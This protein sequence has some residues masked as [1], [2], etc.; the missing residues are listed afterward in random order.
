MDS[1]Q[2]NETLTESNL[3]E[4][5]E[6][7]S[8]FNGD[9]ITKKD[10]KGRFLGKGGFAKCYELK[11]VS[12]KKVFAGKIISKA[13][14]IKPSAKNKLKSEIKIHKSLSHPNIVKFE[15]YFED[16]E[17]V[18]ILLELCKSKTLN[19]L[20]K[21]RKILSEI[22]VKYYLFQILNAVKF[23]HKSKVIHRDLKLG[24]L[25]LSGSLEIKIGDFGLATR[26]EYDG[27][28]KHTV[29]GTPNY[30]A[31]EILENKSN[32]HSYE[33]DYWAIGVIVYTLL[34][35]KP[36]FETDD[37]KETYKK[38]NANIYSFPSHIFITDNAKDFI[39]KIL[40]TNP[41]NR[42]TPDM[43]L[44]HPFM[45][46]SPIPKEMPHYTLSN[47]PKVD[48]F[49][50][51]PNENIGKITSPTQLS[52]DN[53]KENLEMLRNFALKNLKKCD[54]MNR[55]FIDLKASEKYN[56]EL[57]SSGNK[58]NHE[59]LKKKLEEFDMKKLVY[60]DT[61]YDYSE[62]FGILFKM[63]VNNI[64]GCVYND[65]SVLF[66]Y[67]GKNN[68]CYENRKKKVHKV[69]DSKNIISSI[70]Q[71]YEILINFEKYLSTSKDQTLSKQNSSNSSLNI[72]CIYVQKIIKND[73][74]ILLKLSNKVIQ[75]TFRDNTKIVIDKDLS[76]RVFFFD[77]N[78]KKYNYSIHSVNKC[79]NKRFM[80]RYEH[81]KKIYF[82]KMD[83]RF[84]KIQQMKELDTSS[85]HGN[86]DLNKTT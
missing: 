49:R 10:V 30:I 47:P 1:E 37:V 22:E 75:L 8:K 73:I 44:L 15:H 56:N 60:C 18:Y 83:E 86:F 67:Y 69:F 20:L 51:Y 72:N 80:N 53:D 66:K 40:V 23:M 25:F 34:I 58:E 42:L 43:M 21:K 50:G 14:I 85:S 5:E 46:A 33:V 29:C 81:Y 16:N 76:Q 24:N 27:E 71:K 45:N 36:P 59:L 19:E 65:K 4:I 68:V 61:V 74:S 12:N 11:C 54:E 28:R 2:E 52:F 70:K 7:I 13:N 78:N 38:I 57:N 26:V 35:G 6:H 77:K 82:E 63:S 9:E 62:K 64:I 32:G 3:E 48:F 79:T 84:Q 39:K 17:N 41:N 31:P 55:G